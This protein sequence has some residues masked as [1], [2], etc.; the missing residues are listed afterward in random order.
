MTAK[1][2]PEISVK[3]R[4]DDNAKEAASHVAHGLHQVSEGAEKSSASSSKAMMLA[5]AAAGA[6]AAGVA[7]AVEAAK[8]GFEAFIGLGE[9]A[10]EAFMASEEQVRGLAGTLTLIDQNANSFEDLNELAG[11]LKDE[12]EG[13]A[14]QA[15]VTD[16]AMVAAFD[17]IIERGGKGV[18]EARELAASMAY[19]GR[20]VKGGTESLSAGFEAIQMGM[21][22]AKNPVVQLIASTHMLK[23]SAKE[24][25]KQMQKMTIVEQMELAE[26]AIGRMGEKMKAAPMTIAQMKTSMGVAFENLFEEMGA[27]IVKALDPIVGKVRDL[28]LENGGALQEGAR[29]FGKLM[30]QGL[31]VVLPLIDAASAAIKAN[32]GELTAETGKMLANAKET[33]DYISKNKEAIA[34]TAVDI[35]KVL[36]TAGNLFLNPIRAMLAIVKA[37][38]KFLMKAADAMHLFGSTK[39]GKYGALEGLQIDEAREKAG[40]ALRG[41]IQSFAPGKPID[42]GYRKELHDKFIKEMKDAGADALDAEEAYTSAYSAAAADHDRSMAQVAKYRDGA[43]AADAASFAKAW[44][45]AERS[46]DEGTKEYVASF[47]A[48]NRDLVKQIAEK[49]PEILGSGFQDL[50]TKLEG[51]HSGIAGELK[52]GHKI[53]LGKANVIQNFSGGITIK[54]DF[55][56]QD[57]DRV[58]AVFKSDLMK[59]G[60]NRIQSTFAMPGGF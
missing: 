51:M 20:A 60:T 24:V 46:N 50:V 13:V 6:A 17:D 29:N 55:R 57:P 14:I 49:G 21:V 33:L 44:D 43:V 28:F 16:D 1:K 3:L 34:Q 23:G 8:G 27:P 41:Q 2:G 9:H 7:L 10:A 31:D 19:A 11:E 53:E 58:A 39:G 12:L 32:W 15:G 37:E 48:A 35:G 26:K 42:E 59:E 45:I 56:D 52:S 40:G 4:I 38:V 47:L 5:G 22:R 54:Q 36:V 30:S 18:E 25:A